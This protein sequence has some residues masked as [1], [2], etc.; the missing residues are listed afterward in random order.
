MS[1]LLPLALLL[2]AAP[3]VAAPVPKV[4]LT[5]EQEAEFNDLWDGVNGRQATSIQQY[6]RL[7][8]QPDA[9]VEYI[10]KTV[11]PAKLDKDEAKRLIADLGSEDDAVWRAAARDLR[12]R[13][14]RLTV[15][16]TDAWKWAETYEQKLR[17]GLTLC[18]YSAL[19]ADPRW[20][21]KLI[22]PRT[23]GEKSSI[24]Y[25]NDTGES[26]KTGWSQKVFETFDE[27]VAHRKQHK[28]PSDGDSGIVAYALERIGT[29]DARRHLEALAKGHPDAFITREASAALKRLKEK[30][31]VPKAELAQLWRLDLYKFIDTDTPNAFLDRPDEAVAFLKK[32]LRPVTL[33][34]DGAKKLLARLLSDEPK[35]VREALRELQVIDLALEMN[36]KDA[37]EELTTPEHR[38][39]LAAAIGLWEELPYGGITDDFDIDIRY[40][41]YDYSIAGSHGSGLRL[42][43]YVLWKMWRDEAPN[44]VRRDRPRDRR[45]S[46]TLCRTKDE[47]HRDRWYHEECAIAILDA[48][49]TDDALALVKDMATGH[50]DAGPTKAAKAVLKRRGK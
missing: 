12:N 20:K 16:F 23:K 36:L 43:R 28:V 30:D 50:P 35:E 17:L 22:A 10:T 29:P 26:I 39:R 34:A 45:M 33:T 24:E 18:G 47:I 46:E 42:E 49:G 11:K 48:I 44:G 14:V 7:V 40:K 38:C 27:L 31:T 41:D 37:F 1:R 25:M 15:N 19:G 6:C 21:L 32:S 13:D 2:L 9:A 8:S 5:K 4:P 3:A